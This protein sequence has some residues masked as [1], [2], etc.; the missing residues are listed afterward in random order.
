MTPKF[1]DIVFFTLLNMSV[2][3]IL[4]VLRKLKLSISRVTLAKP[5]LA[6]YPGSGYEAK[7]DP[8][9]LTFVH[10]PR[11]SKGAGTKLFRS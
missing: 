8:T 11:F 7:P 6:S 1:N 9:V 2:V 3:T 10:R 5:D 4:I